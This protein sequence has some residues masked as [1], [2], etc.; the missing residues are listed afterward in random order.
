M[1]REAWHVL[2]PGSERSPV[3]RWGVSSRD[4]APAPPSPTA[5]DDAAPSDPEHA[6]ASS[7]A[8]A[9]AALAGV[10]AAAL[11]LA[12]ATLLAAV[13]NPSASP[14]QSI[15]S[16]VV[17]LV[18]QWLKQGVIALFGTADKAVLFL[19]MGAVAV[20]LAALAGLASLRDRRLGTAVVVVLGLI[21][22]AA[23]VTR[24]SGGA[25]A[26][27]PSLVGFG[28]GVLV[29]RPLVDAARRAPGAP[30]DDGTSRRSFV[31]LA[32]ATALGAGVAAAGARLVTAGGQVVTSARAAVR[33]PRPT[34]PANPLPEGVSLGIDGVAPFVTPNEDFYRIDTALRVPQVDPADWSLRIHGLVREE[35]TLTWD[36]LLESDLVESWVTLACVSNEVG[37]GLI[38]NARWLGLPTAALLERAGVEQGADMVLSSSSDGF[39]AGTPIDALADPSRGSLLAIGMNGEPLPVEHGFPARLVV[40]GLYGYVSATK[41]VVDLE[42]TRF[43]DATAYWTR[44]GWS[45]E[46]P[47]KTQSRIDVPLRPV[48]AGTVT[49]AGVAWAQTRGVAA[50]EVQVDDGPWNRARLAEAPNA[51][52]WRQWVYA[53]EGATAGQHRL[54]VRAT[55]EDGETQTSAQVGVVPDGATGWD[56]ITVEVT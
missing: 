54:T 38:G 17:D 1:G 53:W 56:T 7:N 28:A 19:A 30:A 23:A 46:G 25:S 48:P 15:G 9:R 14:L 18:P 2:G 22:V 10:L 34:A 40:P 21:T 8:R 29:L 42:V 27:I 26:A 24:A 36:E 31:T 55:D 49:V 5:S 16:A 39:T 13:I 43:A 33:L 11:A 37:G 45:A 52:T 20:V 41:W 51:D 6:P 35:I 50:V 3:G 12:V 4:T 32:V 47:I 44:R